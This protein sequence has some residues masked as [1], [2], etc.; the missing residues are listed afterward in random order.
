MKLKHNKKD[1]ERHVESQMEAGEE[2]AVL[3]PMDLMPGKRIDKKEDL[4]KTFTKK[5]D[6]L[7]E[8]ETESINISVTHE[9]ISSKDEK[10]LE[11]SKSKTKYI[12]Y[13]KIQDVLPK[14]EPETVRTK[15]EH[16]PVMEVLKEK[17]QEVSEE[18]VRIA[19]SGE[20]GSF[21]QKVDLS[22]TPKEVQE[23][24]GRTD[25]KQDARTAQK[26]AA[27][28]TETPSKLSKK[29]LVPAK[30]ITS[31]KSAVVWLQT[32]EDLRQTPKTE[33]EM[34]EELEGLAVFKQEEQIS[35]AKLDSAAGDVFIKGE[36]KKVLQVSKVKQ[37]KESKTAP[38]EDIKAP[39]E[40]KIPVTVQEAL[41]ESDVP[42]KAKLTEELP[43][44]IEEVIIFK[45]K[46]DS[47]VSKSFEVCPEAKVSRCKEDITKPLEKTKPVPLEK[48]FVSDKGQTMPKK[49]FKDE[50][51]ATC[52]LDGAILY[53]K[54]LP[55]THMKTA[56]KRNAKGHQR[57]INTDVSL[58]DTA[59]SK[60]V[61][62]SEKHLKDVNILRKKQFYL[63][64]CTR[65]WYKPAKRKRFW[66]KPKK[67]CQKLHARMIRK[68][69]LQR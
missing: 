27:N 66:I 19:V 32:G 20:V 36:E 15:A 43:E 6:F 29:G 38:I 30:D 28:H 41:Y 58:K 47:H 50:I 46:E 22:E 18:I 48:E 57:R 67:I 59:P 16:A 1:Q 69:L 13:E 49:A 61:T 17:M 51:I 4:P 10:G 25:L 21:S 12:V 52:G 3:K 11:I 37:V 35:E 33:A 45:E 42:K 7:K 62:A 60:E 39:K 31:E 9:K 2:S 8:S 44:D 14:A 54:E 40:A 5:M 23:T 26:T 64:T 65:K 55:E 24:K 68:N 63:K 34:S 53:K 56:E